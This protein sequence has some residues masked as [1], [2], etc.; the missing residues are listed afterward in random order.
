MGGRNVHPR[1]LA[2]QDLV[3][4]G[5]ALTSSVCVIQPYNPGVGLCFGGDE[6]LVF[7]ADRPVAFRADRPAILLADRLFPDLPDDFFADRFDFFA[8]TISLRVVPHI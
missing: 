7:F 3:A 1:T 6:A 8:I 4:T 2:A 5:S